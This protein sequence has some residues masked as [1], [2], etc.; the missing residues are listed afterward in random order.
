MCDEC[1]Y[2][3]NEKTNLNRHI[4]IVH[5]KEMPF[6]CDHCPRRFSCK[7]NLQKHK[8]RNTC[9]V[10]ESIGDVNDNK[11]ISDIKIERTLEYLEQTLEIKKESNPLS[12]KYMCDECDY[13]TN[14]NTDL[15]KHIK[16]IHKKEMP[17]SCDHCPKRFSS[18]GNLNQHN[19][20]NTCR[21]KES[22]VIIKTEGTLD[23]LEQMEHTLDIKK[24]SNL[25][26]DD[27]LNTDRTYRCNLVFEGTAYIYMFDLYSNGHHFQDWILFLCP[28][29]VPFVP[30]CLKF[31]L[32]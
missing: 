27:H 25:E 4:K 19:R 3:T 2:K 8:K 13:K 17:F 1:D 16:T 26:N 11:N 7:S 30:N 23:N 10:I 24:E 29:C 15:N 32:F 5:K 31:L 12:K 28:M 21:V 6:S 18:K 9:G 20:R 22:I 14:Y